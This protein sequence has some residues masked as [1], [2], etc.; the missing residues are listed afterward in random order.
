MY[1]LLREAIW[2]YIHNRRHASVPPEG[3]PID[4]YTL[5]LAAACRPTSWDYAKF[6]H[7]CND[8]RLFCHEARHQSSAGLH[9]FTRNLSIHYLGK[10]LSGLDIMQLDAHAE[11][12]AYDCL[13][14]VLTS[15]Y[16]L[17]TAALIHAT[18]QY[19]PTPKKEQ[20]TK[21]GNDIRDLSSAITQGDW[22]EHVERTLL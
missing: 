2:Y 6:W 4:L 22:K 1:A 21:L 5:T 13:I 8:L 18:A 19:L 16:Y 10:V 3:Q 14:G 12:A 11:A 20:L 15:I 9:K 7:T 17:Q